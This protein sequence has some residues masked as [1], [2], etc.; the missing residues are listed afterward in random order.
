M[1][2]NLDRELAEI[3]R[4]PMELKVAE[5]SQNRNMQLRDYQQECLA[6]IGSAYAGGVT[7]QLIA[8]PTGTGK[9]VIF[10]QVPSL[11]PGKRM[12]VIA[13]R[14][15]LLEQAAEKIEWANPNLHIEIEQANRVASGHADVVVGSIQSLSGR[16]GKDRLERL[17]PDSFS[18]VIIDE[19]HHALAMTYLEFLARF[20]KAP[21]L[22]DISSKASGKALN[23]ILSERCAG[24]TPDPAGPLLVGFT[25][26]PHRT[27]GVGLHYVF[28][29]IPFSRT[30]KEM[31]TAPLPGPWLCPIKGYRFESGL[32]LKGVKTSHGDYQAR[33][34]SEVVNNEERNIAAVKAYMALASGRQAICFCVD[35]A[36]T[37]AMQEQFASYGVLAACIVGADDS[38]DRRK[39]VADFKAGRIEVLVNCMVLTEGFDHAATACIIMARPTKSQLLY[40]QMLGRG[41]RLAPPDK[42]N[43]MVIDLAD[44]DAVGVASVNTLFGL[45][46]GLET[47]KG[48]V[49]T[50]EEFDLIIEEQQVDPGMVDGAQTIEEVRAMACEYNPLGIPRIPDYIRHTM[51]WAKTA[52]GYVL[53][54]N[55][56]V[57]VGIVL[58]LLEHA[59]V[60][61]KRRD[62]LHRTPTRVEMYGSAYTT[63]SAAIEAVEHM[64][65]DHY[66]DECGFLYK[67][68]AWRIRGQNEPATDKQL[69]YL[70]SLKVMCPEGLTKSDAGELITKAVAERNF[71]KG[72]E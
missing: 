47:K 18:T 49:E 39:T 53:T 56:D 12:L 29:E 72:K 43:L 67:N 2:N 1:V 66:P 22:S 70:K 58:D 36:H 32:S 20:G 63:V 27:D 4:G 8:L 23:R 5:A 35:V 48:V 52:F 21:D 64:V 40:T 19:A 59:Q 24:F 55:K 3:L 9:T 25:A 71:K 60:Q 68:A 37:K 65:E 51:T 15:E 44:T 45:P 28:D 31:M 46:P 26:T 6:K 38:E 16:Y 57:S 62:P 10:S 42:D 14:E 11:F 50:Q 41:T 30:I 13:H 17:N 69:Q 61:I 33:S 34:L 54:V 7:R